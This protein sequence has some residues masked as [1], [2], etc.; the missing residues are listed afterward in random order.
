MTKSWHIDTLLPAAEKFY[1]QLEAHFKIEI[2][3]PIPLLR[4][5][6]NTDDAKRLGRRMRNP[7]YANV[8]GKYHP[9]ASGH[10][11][12]VDA[13]GSFEIKNAAYVDLPLC[14]Q[15]LQQ[16]FNKSGQLIDTTF[17]HSD[18]VKAT[19]GWSYQNIDAR[20]I[21]FCEGIGIQKNPW[22]QN[23]PLTPAK[24]ETL[25]I[26]APGLEL[27][28]TLYHHKK[29]LLPY[30]SQEYRVGATYDEADLS[31]EPTA[32]GAQQLLDA[33]Q[34][35]LVE[36]TQLN[37]RQ[38]LA[39]IRPS[40]RDARPLLGTH[41]TEPRL[42]LFNGLGSKGTSLAPEMARLL[43]EHIYSDLPL[44]PEID[45]NRFDSTCD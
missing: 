15:N 1:R 16:H 42:H 11:A 22:F 29:W 32:E 31:P 9:P 28:K 17:D 33:V 14:I 12:L 39:G 20:R 34:D 10:P 7:R 37:I 13:Q 8:L 3:H 19:E 4:Y 18:L 21:I 5:C 40:T 45:L 38:H 6:Q 26:D 2:Y 36:D 24:G 44:S 43:I 35:F 41:P 30:G 23:L 27:P 25:I